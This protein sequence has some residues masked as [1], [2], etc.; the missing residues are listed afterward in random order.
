MVMLDWYWRML[1]ESGLTE[2]WLAKGDLVQARS[3]AERF[4]EITLATSERT[5]QALAWEANARVAMAEDDVQRAQD[6]IAKALSTMEGFEVPLAA[7][8]VRAT[9]ADLAQ[10]AGNEEL[11]AHNRELSRATIL[12]LAN[13]LPAEE[14]L[15]NTFLSAPSVSKVL[16]N[17]ER[18]SQIESSRPSASTTS[19][20][21]SVGHEK[22]RTR[23]IEHTARI[24]FTESP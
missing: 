2:V 20:V 19:T 21:V 7:W 5:W 23:P 6:C 12:K 9:A 22:R 8:R 1:L 16:G 11:A 3:Q 13:S 4:L 10:H 15:R 18:S 14:S 24:L 17:A